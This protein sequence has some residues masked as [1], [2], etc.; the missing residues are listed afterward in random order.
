MVRLAL[1]ALLSLAAGCLRSTTFRCATDAECGTGTCES[2]GFCAFADSTCT[3]GRRYGDHSEQYSG[4]CVGDVIPIDGGV[5]ATDG[6]GDAFVPDA[7]VGCAVD[8][9]TITGGQAGRRYKRRGNLATW[10]QHRSACVSEGG[11]LTIPGDAT[12]LA[13]IVTLGA[14]ATFVG[15]SD[16]AVEGS[17]RDVLGVPATFLPWA[18]GQ[19][20]DDNPGEDCVRASGTTLTDERCSRTGIAVC[21]CIE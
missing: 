1:L 12:E 14:A 16:V 4:T 17:W 21:E 19:P 5:D 15:I 20:D 18:S 8:Y 3:E 11:H 10:D 6:M 9:L 7:F 13:A 2:V